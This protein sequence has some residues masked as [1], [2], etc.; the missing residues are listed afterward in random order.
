MKIKFIFLF[1]GS[2]GQSGIASKIFE[3]PTLISLSV[4]EPN[5]ADCKLPAKSKLMEEVETSSFSVEYDDIGYNVPPLTVLAGSNQTGL[6]FK[7]WVS[8][9][10]L[11]LGW[12]DM[13]F[14]LYSSSL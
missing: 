3:S 10:S 5:C 8:K 1:P 7:I 4:K 9:T 14:P 6:V 13:R 12:R 2:E 11:P